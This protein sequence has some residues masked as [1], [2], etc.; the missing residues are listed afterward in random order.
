MG[1]K[2]NRPVLFLKGCQFGYGF[3]GTCCVQQ[4]LRQGSWLRFTDEGA[5]TPSRLGPF[6]LVLG[7]AWEVRVLHCS[8]P[9]TGIREKAACVSLT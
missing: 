8:P 1:E 5:E 7:H 6:S 9:R 3:S 2:L 4:H